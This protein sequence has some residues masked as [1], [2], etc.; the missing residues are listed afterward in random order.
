MH[1][2]KRSTYAVANAAFRVDLLSRYALITCE[3]KHCCSAFLGFYTTIHHKQLLSIV[4]S[5]P[6]Q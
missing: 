3:F 5:Q 1:Q 4:S 6:A 2:C